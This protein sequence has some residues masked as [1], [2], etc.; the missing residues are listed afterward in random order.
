MRYIHHPLIRPG[1]IEERSYQISIALRALESPTMVVLPTGLGKTAIALLVAASR[2]YNEGGRIL[3]LAPTRP[4]VEQH[5]RFFLKH[6][7]TRDGQDPDTGQFV[8][9][10]GETPPEKRVHAWNK[11][12]IC[13]AT[14]QVIKNDIIAGRYSLT[15]VTLM[16]VDECHRAVGNYAYVFLAGEYRRT[17]KNPLILA[18]T[19]SPGSMKEKVEEICTNLGIEH[20]ES[21]VETDPDVRPYIHPRQIRTVT[22]ELPPQ[23]RSVLDDLI[24]MLDSRLKR[25]R[26][27]GFQVPAAGSLSMK[28]LN[29]LHAQIQ[30]EISR[31]SPS[32]YT[33]ASLY[34]EVMKLRHAIT[35]AESQG[36]TA[37]RRYIERLDSGAGSSKGSRASMRIIADPR[38][39]SLA[40]RVK[41]WHSELHPKAVHVV[42]EVRTEL[43]RNPES[44]IIVFATYRDTVGMLT[45]LLQQSGI[46]CERFVGQ[47]SRDAGKGLS[48]KRQLE[49]LARFRRGDFRVLVST[50]VGEEGLDV[51]STDLVIFY[52]A[53][54]SEIRRIQRKGRTGRS[55]AGSILVLVTKGTSDEVFNYVSRQREKSMVNGIRGQCDRRRSGM[56]P[57]S[58]TPVSV[59]KSGQTA[60]GSFLY[61]EPEIRADDREGASRVVET[62][63][64][65][66]IRVTLC[67][68][69]HGDYSIGDRILVER[70]TVSDFLDTLINRN[71]LRQMRDLGGAAPRPILILE[72]DEDIYSGRNLHPNAIRGTLAAIAADFG[73]S[74]IPTRD[75]DDTAQMLA[76]LA[77]REEGG[78]EERTPHVRKSYRSLK[79]S[80]EYILSAFPGV[81]PANARRLLAHFGSIRAVITASP[82]ELKAVKGI[83]EKT[84]AAIA[85]LAGR[86]YR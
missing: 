11:A 64:R 58:E 85:E 75:A 5:R 20:V 76:I 79:E 81:G 9:F 1:S 26:A 57:Q 67:R 21:R 27:L 63:H 16:V 22:V 31:R 54:P 24:A 55:R 19:A 86:D 52:E 68:L 78:R 42:D 65:L 7:L 46:D 13:F 30:S 35:L 66:G 33:A 61:P 62:L 29:R 10:T 48:Q 45:E 73:I 59:P 82:E 84:A 28:A 36:S 69:E 12:H 49:T 17:A 32:G 25:L 3:V 60:I 50:S 15:D 39:R 77:K 4:L 43:E 44:R 34:A 8:M 2:F 72:G 14:P 53:V 23:L 70:K 74:I 47:A 38:F 18:M 51:P 41:E 37:L 40:A 83:G 71:L 6:L 80:Q 56:P